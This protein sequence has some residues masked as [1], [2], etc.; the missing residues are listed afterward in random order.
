MFV[1]GGGALWHYYKVY[2]QPLNS[3][4]LLLPDKSCFLPRNDLLNC[5]DKMWPLQRKGIKQV[6][7]TGVAGSGKTTLARAY[8]KRQSIKFVYEIN[9]ET[10]E[11]L[12]NS[13]FN[14]I[15]CFVLDSQEL[16][17]FKNIRSIQNMGKQISDLVIMAQSKLAKVKS[18]LL[19]IDNLEIDLPFLSFLNHGLCKNG[20][21]VIT[22]RN[23]N[24][25]PL[26]QPL[27][28]VVPSLKPYE[29]QW[30][31]ERISHCKLRPEERQ[32]FLNE[33]PQFP[34]DIST[35]A[36]YI[37]IHQIDYQAYLQSIFRN[38]AASE[39]LQ[40]TIKGSLAYYPH[41]REGIIE[42]GCKAI[43]DKHRSFAGLLLYIS[44]FDSQKIPQVFLESTE[45][46]AIV[47]LFLHTL[48]S[49]SLIAHR[50]R[51]IY[52]HRSIQTIMFDFLKEEMKAT[53]RDEE[54]K[55]IKEVCQY[56]EKIINQGDVKAARL[57]L[58]HV[59]SMVRKIPEAPLL[60]PLHALAGNLYFLLGHYPEAQKLF[61]KSL[62][63][64]SS[65]PSV[66]DVKIWAGLAMTL[67]KI[68]LYED[69]EKFLKKSITLYKK[70]SVVF[71]QEHAWLLLQIG[72]MY[73]HLDRA[74]PAQQALEKS[75]SF[76]ENSGKKDL[77]I[78]KVSNFIYIGNTYY[79]LDVTTKKRF[80]NI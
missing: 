13:L 58:I 52:I 59:L 38:K 43:L 25:P 60:K 65:S 40:G 5:I 63:Y 30:L 53:L 45:S 4:P 14:L 6:F 68:G 54:E 18:W 73:N 41:Y 12:I 26:N 23:Q 2:S 64:S 36:Y 1:G 77:E 11:N 24:L 37:R 44:L 46:P 19:I 56:G 79:I 70:N 50:D 39:M 31:F 33:L 72:N 20:R 61:E 78:H 69:M 74:V 62:P 22:T 51:H 75:L 42:T 80:P 48:K 3:L 57:L 10:L 21:V 28:I 49:H 35:V 71:S 15:E 76:Y 16:Q 66:Q 8:A 9:A 17:R 55:I 32:S 67:K 34:L 47:A 7:L 29:S 27:Q